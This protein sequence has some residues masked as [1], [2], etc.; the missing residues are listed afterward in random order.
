MRVEHMRF[1]RKVADSGSISQAANELFISHQMLSAIMRKMED[2]VG[3]PLLIRHHTGVSLTE[4]GKE[5]Y[6]CAGNITALYEDYLKK[7][8][9]WDAGLSGSLEVHILPMVETQAGEILTRFSE[10][11]PDVIIDARN[12]SYEEILETFRN[13]PDKSISRVALIVIPPLEM[14]G[15]QK[16]N[17]ELSFTP[18]KQNRFSVAVQKS[19]HLAKLESISFDELLRYPLISYESPIGISRYMQALLRRNGRPNIVFSSGNISLCL[20]AASRRQGAFLV[21]DDSDTNP[22]FQNVFSSLARIPI[23]G[24]MAFTMGCLLYENEKNRPLQASFLRSAKEY[25]GL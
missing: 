20:Q 24:D 25:F 12:S 11:H 1:F 19:S 23:E 10:V 15:F 14:E 9:H 2:D 7:V 6:D 21:P 18:L 8:H 13:Y 4:A 16:Q 3:T 17:R 5:L 22:L